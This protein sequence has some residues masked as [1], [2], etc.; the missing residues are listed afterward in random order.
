[1]GLIWV[2]ATEYASL[3]SEADTIGSLDF[4]YLRA[5]ESASRSI[6]IGNTGASPV[7]VN[8]DTDDPYLD[9][10]SEPIDL[11]AGRISDTLTVTVNAPLEAVSGV[12][13]NTLSATTGSGEI[14]ALSVSYSL[15]GAFTERSPQYPERAGAFTDNVTGVLVTFSEPLV[16]HRYDPIP[17]DATDQRVFG[18]RDGE[19][20]KL[21][22][23]ADPCS[24][25]NPLNQT[26]GYLHSTSTIQASFQ[27]EDMSTP[28]APSP[29]NTAGR[30]GASATLF[31][32]AHVNLERD[33]QLFSPARGADRDQFKRTVYVVVRQGKIWALQDVVSVYRGNEIGYYRCRLTPVQQRTPADPSG[34]NPWSITYDYWSDKPYAIYPCSLPGGLL[35]YDEN[36][37]YIPP[38]SGSSA[39]NPVVIALTTQPEFPTLQISGEFEGQALAHVSVSGHGDLSVQA[40]TWDSSVV[41]IQAARVETTSTDWSLWILQNDNGLAANDA[42][43]PA[44]A[45]AEHRSGNKDLGFSLLYEDEDN[46]SSVHLHFLDNTGANLEATISLSG[47]RKN[48]AFTAV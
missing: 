41:Q 37:P 48:I 39:S 36:D 1:M 35:L 2:P 45:I 34:F 8:L 32:P 10:P 40:D 13:L 29:E 43:V 14:V 33:W 22:T 15:V 19:T 28:D 38:F 24:R 42:Q 23:L 7:V 27:S 6:R 44:R 9:Y 31:L 21:L 47:I 4:G 20:I 12:V 26:W 46:T 18:I 17:Y 11:E 3:A 25:L 16:L 5:G 30:Y